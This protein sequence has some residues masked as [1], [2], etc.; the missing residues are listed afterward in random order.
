MDTNNYL[1]FSALTYKLV[2]LAVG[3]LAVYLGYRLFSKGIWG[4]SGDLQAKFSDTRLVLKNGAPGTFFAVM[5][6]VI[7][8][9]T[10]MSGFKGK[11]EISGNSAVLQTDTQ[12][13][14]PQKEV[15]KPPLD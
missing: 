9:A 11:N 4:Q 6:A 15:N 13:N 5:G 1:I 8:C 10:I 2:C 12:L 14:K 7:I 3:G